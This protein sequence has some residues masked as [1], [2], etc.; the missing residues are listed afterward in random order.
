MNPTCLSDF[1][2]P[3]DLN[4]DLTSVLIHPKL[5]TS[6]VPQH[7]A[8]KVKEI[9]K[10]GRNQPT[11]NQLLTA[12]GQPP[13]R[14]TRTSIQT[15]P[16]LKKTRRWIHPTRIMPL[17][18]VQMPQPR[19]MDQFPIAWALDLMHGLNM[20]G[21]RIGNVISILYHPRKTIIESPTYK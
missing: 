18:L 9:G 3:L 11:L 12:T 14:S 7:H 1:K 20:G 10:H 21:G 17:N 4:V 19:Q 5:M 2:D 13:I 15:I 8:N 16:T 6:T